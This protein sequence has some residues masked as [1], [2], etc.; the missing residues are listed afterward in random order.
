MTKQ[1]SS[2]SKKDLKNRISILGLYSNEQELELN[3]SKTKVM[4]FSKQGA[5][6]RKFNL[7]LQGQEM[8]MV[9]QYTYLGFTF[10]PSEKHQEIENLINKV[11]NS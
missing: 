9:N 7:F 1:F 3:L 6:I 10:T 5:T 11:K 8:E 4:T 2:L